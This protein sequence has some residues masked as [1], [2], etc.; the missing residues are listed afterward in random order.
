[1]RA[2]DAWYLGVN[3]NIILSATSGMAAHWEGLNPWLFGLVGFATW[4][5]VLGGVLW[6]A[7]RHTP[8]DPPPD[9]HYP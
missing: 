1:M 9:Y 5:V 4:G 3:L 6:Y 8:P 7:V 2:N